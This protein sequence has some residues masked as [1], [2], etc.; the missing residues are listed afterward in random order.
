MACAEGSVSGVPALLLRIGFVGE[1]GWE[2]HFP[3][4]CGEYL[5][6]RLLES[7]RQSGCRPVGVEAQRL[8]RLEKKH[9]IVGQDTDALSNPYEADM[10]WIVRLDKEDF[11][12]RR[13]LANLQ[14][15]KI[16]NRLVGF[17]M[18]DGVCPQDGNAVVIEGKLAGRVT[19]ARF[20][21]AWNEYVGMAW[22]PVEFAKEGT[23]IE[24]HVDGRLG[25]ATIVE[26]PFYDPAGV[27]LK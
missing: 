8:L 12:G 3:A 7:G 23:R 21:P 24:V 14:R 16:R 17:R 10:S 26:K 9:I 2:I 4:E 15:R 1:T 11:V 19:S 22:V 20:S 13:A 5:W 27:R 18:S 25:A 6:D